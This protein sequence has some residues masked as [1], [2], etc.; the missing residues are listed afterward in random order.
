MKKL[1]VILFAVVM[2]LGL[3]IAGGAVIPRA[4]FGYGWGV[5]Y[6]LTEQ[7]YLD[8][9]GWWVTRGYVVFQ[10]PLPCARCRHWQNGYINGMNSARWLKGARRSTALPGLPDRIYSPWHPLK[11]DE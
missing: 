9:D 10:E 5:I 3:Y 7:H 8:D 11:D 6:G 2:L 4:E 1:I